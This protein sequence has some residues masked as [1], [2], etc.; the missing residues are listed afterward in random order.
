MATNTFGSATNAICDTQPDGTGMA[1]VALLKFDPSSLT[2]APRQA[3]LQLAVSASSVRNG[4]VMF[5]V[6]RLTTDW[7]ENATTAQAQPNSSLSWAAGTFSAADYDPQPVGVGVTAGGSGLNTFVD[8][9]ALVQNWVGGVSPNYGVVVI[10]QPI[11]NQP[12]TDGSNLQ[13]FNIGTREAASAQRP[14]ISCIRR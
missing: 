6:Y 3:E 7:D 13:Q 10:A 12:V 8:I 11:W 4:P 9:T 14:Q 5:Y 1:D 2:S